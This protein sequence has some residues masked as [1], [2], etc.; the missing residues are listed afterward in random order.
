M[1]HCIKVDYKSLIIGVE[2][3]LLSSVVFDVLSSSLD[4]LEN[5]SQDEQKIIPTSAW[6]HMA[7]RGM[8]K[9]LELVS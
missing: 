7:P 9:R 8:K 2:N 6:A 1:S 4:S 5:Q 3:S